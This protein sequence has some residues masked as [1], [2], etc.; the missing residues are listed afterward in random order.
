MKSKILKRV[1]SGVM[2]ALA[3]CS[4]S[5]LGA[6]AESGLSMSP[7]KQSIVLD[8]GETYQS[9]L[10]ISNPGT[11][12]FD[13][14]YLVE[15]KPF[16]VN[17]KYESVF[18]E[19]ERYSQIVDWIKLDSPTTGSVAPNETK[20]IRFTI[21]VPSWA[22]AG[23]QYAS[24]LVS[25]AGDDDNKEMTINEKMA[26]G[27][28]LFVEIAGDT[29]KQGEFS[30]VSVPGFLFSGNITGTSSIKN[31]G[32]THGE[33]T[34]K[35]QVYP[36]FSSEEVYSN[37][38]EPVKKLIL[39]DRTY[40]SNDVSW[41]KTPS[42]GIFNVVYTVEFEGVTKQVSKMVIVCPIWL[43]FIVL[44]LVAGL[45]I[46]LLMKFTSKGKKGKRAATTGISDDG[47]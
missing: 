17:D 6:F 36:L 18:E 38:D 31:T 9:S 43:L 42:I 26:L 37:E 45:V 41:D 47:E 29:R 35:L 32:N 15:V 16:Y 7:M 3:F 12:T 40:Y 20:E 46:W 8:A 27:H 33:A 11:S 24:I 25:S 22:P 30:D 28:I 2:L 19:N 23:G 14:K 13:F 44:A 39:P 1:V 10:S 5:S 21:N 34:Y 4:C